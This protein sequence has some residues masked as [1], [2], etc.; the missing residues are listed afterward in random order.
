[1]REINGKKLY[2]LPS[3]PDS[4]MAKKFMEK[5]DIFFDVDS[6]RN[7]Q[8]EILRNTG[9]DAPIFEHELP[10][11]ENP[12]RT[13]ILQMHASGS[14]YSHDPYHPELFLGDLDR[15]SRGVY[16]EPNVSQ[17]ADQAKFRQTR[18]IEKKLQDDPDKRVEGVASSRAIDRAAKGGF[19]DNAARLTNMF[20][21][22]TDADVRRSNPNPGRTIQNPDDF[23]KEDQKYY[24]SN[25]EKIIPKMGYNPASAISN[26]IGTE[27]ASQPDM[28]FGLSSVSNTYRA[29]GDVDA[30]TVAAFRSGVQD[31]VFN[32]S[33]INIQ[34]TAMARV[35]DAVKADKQIQH[36]AE[37]SLKT[38]SRQSQI[39]Q[40]MAMPAK[41]DGGNAVNKTA[42]SQKKSMQRE[43][44]TTLLKPQNGNNQV[45]LGMV[46]ARKQHSADLNVDQRKMTVPKK[47]QMKISRSIRKDGKQLKVGSEHFAQ[48]YTKNTKALANAFTQRIEQYR[49]QSGTHTNRPNDQSQVYSQ[50]K[51]HN[52]EDR[53]SNVKH[54]DVKFGTYQERLV[55]NPIGAAQI[56]EVKQTNIGN[57]EFDTDPA[58]DNQYMTQ[59]KGA[60]KM[61]YIFNE[62]IYDNDIA[63]LSEIV[64]TRRY[65]DSS[66]A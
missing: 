37:V 8:K 66:K 11:T 28:K 42:F 18:Y 41:H 26:T 38:D 6:V 2:D 36:S 62:R 43:T 29:K 10:R 31:A 4:V 57:Y 39:A 50:A 56:K 17:M 15:D 40:R 44:F 16:N 53:I 60:Q 61:G 65:I 24:E 58:M 45:N 7:F 23:V 32:E 25:S 1:M 21:D 55:S 33:N 51:M 19:A 13:L 63:P 49:E 59:R 54:T 5:T 14:T 20:D 52:A 3:M 34:A 9:P 48:R 30:S 46:E 64:N 27:W 47:D 35:K 12:H 22:S